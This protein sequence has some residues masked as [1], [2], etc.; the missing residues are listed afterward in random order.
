MNC[1]E[2]QP[3]VSALH[4]GETI[5]PDAARHIAACAACKAR[6]REYSEIGA[7]LRLL[8]SAEPE[9]APAPLGPL[10]DP[11]KHFLGRLNARIL[12]PR[13]ALALGA[14]AILGLTVGLVVIRAQGESAVKLAE[15][16][17]Q[18]RTAALLAQ[19][20]AE[21][22]GPWFRYDVAIPRPRG[23]TKVPWKLGAMIQV[24]GRAE[25]AVVP[26]PFV[27]GAG[28]K[29]AIFEIKAT[30]AKGDSVHLVVRARY[31]EVV[32]GS[33][34]E[35]DLSRVYFEPRVLG[36]FLAGA[37][38][39]DYDYR[40]GQKLVIPMDG[41]G[42]ATLTG[43]LF[44]IKPTI[45]GQ[46][47]TKPGE[48]SFSDGALL[49]RQEFQGK[50]GTPGKYE[51]L[52]TVSGAGGTSSGTNPSFVICAPKV[53]ALLF[54]LK[55]IKGAVKGV[56]EYA[57]ARFT[58]DGE[59]YTLYSATPITGGPQPARIWV[60]R[61]PRCGPNKLTFYRSPFYAG[62]GN[63]PDML[64]FLRETKPHFR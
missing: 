4:D 47:T 7:E 20:H 32:P 53:G 49:R 13:F 3:F 24:G 29:K 61:L 60:L 41:G 9:A 12:V 63:V 51:L 58:V 54:A 43:K 59:D 33:K 52:G 42:T 35:K 14:I 10:P 55:P 22:R 5:P 17:A 48:L 64:K 37:P 23:A 6:L 16:R 1:Q 44:A 34:L 8:A 38:T 19:R 2:A 25:Y 27:G 40:P 31:G 30:Q 62:G 11:H 45:W 56:A 57:Q 50:Y 21:E 46:G 18:S 36:A 26:F 39:H 15:T 28:G